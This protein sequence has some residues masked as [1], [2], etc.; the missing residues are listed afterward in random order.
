MKWL[1]PLLIL[2]FSAN[3][4]I[5]NLTNYT[6]PP[7]SVNHNV[8]I[9]Y[10]ADL[11]SSGKEEDEVDY[12]HLKYLAASIA[13]GQRIIIDIEH[14]YTNS[15]NRRLLNDGVT[16][17]REVLR[18]IKAVNPSI[19]IGIFGRPPWCTA[20][21]GTY[22]RG[23]KEWQAWDRVNKALEPITDYAD[24]IYPTVYPSFANRH[25]QAQWMN[26]VLSA[27]RMYG[28]P[29]IPFISKRWFEVAGESGLSGTVAADDAAYWDHYVETLKKNDI[30]SVVLWDTAASTDPFDYS[31]KWFQDLSFLLGPSSMR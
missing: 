12:E 11:F 9:F 13:D 21:E 15:G 4:E 20:A 16:K 22:Q 19:N 31:A 2:S 27:A 10:A 28:L 5:Y 24:T 1:L 7:I 14:W 6:S 30:T 17:Y 26:N 25:K 3:A 29:V 18:T 8:T 23:T